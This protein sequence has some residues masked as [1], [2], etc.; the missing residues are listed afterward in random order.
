MSAEKSYVSDRS[1]SLHRQGQRDAAQ[2][3]RLMHVAEAARV[4]MA[5]FEDPAPV[6]RLMLEDHS[7][8]RTAED[9][10]RGERRAPLPKKVSKRSPILNTPEWIGSGFWQMLGGRATTA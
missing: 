8:S 3:A 6:P 7:H 4:S 1:A 9:A 5:P 10:W 2:L